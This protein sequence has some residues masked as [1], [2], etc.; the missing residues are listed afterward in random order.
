MLSQLIVNL[1]DVLFLG[2]LF[3]FAFW[4]WKSGFLKMGFGLVSLI[5]AIFLGRMLY[6]YCA[7]FLRNTPIY[8]GILSLAEKNGAGGAID[9]EHGFFADLLAK[10]GELVTEYIAEIALNVVAFVLVVI[11]VKLLLFLISRLLKVFSKLPIISLVN[12]IAGLLVGIL[13]GVLVLTV[14][15]ALI[16]LISPLRES[17][18]LE[19]EIE[20]SVI[21]HRLYYEN[22]LLTFMNQ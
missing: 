1:A 20:K 5:V 6:P 12:R 17:P 8:T 16:S 19:R 3:I 4:G 15:L 11:L 2:I 21:V 14:A 9:A 10:S 7:A 18:V 22:P 13:E